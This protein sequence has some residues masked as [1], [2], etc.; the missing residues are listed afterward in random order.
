MKQQCSVIMGIITINYKWSW[1]TIEKFIGFFFS[2][3]NLWNSSMDVVDKK[4]T[5]IVCSLGCILRGFIRMFVLVIKENDKKKFRRKHAEY[6]WEVRS[7]MVLPFHHV[8]WKKNRVTYGVLDTCDQEW[9]VYRFTYVLLSDKNSNS[10][11]NFSMSYFSSDLW[12]G[13]KWYDKNIPTKRQ[14]LTCKLIN[15]RKTNEKLAQID[16]EPAKRCW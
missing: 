5:L 11:W 7:L 12:Y 14:L 13:K 6:S 8:T 2:I 16:D 15:F 1:V 4:F 3:Q 9:T 10:K